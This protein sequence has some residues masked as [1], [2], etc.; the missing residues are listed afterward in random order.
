MKI[1]RQM[2]FEIIFRIVKYLNKIILN[3]Q[4]LISGIE[5]CLNKNLFNRRFQGTKKWSFFGIFRK[6]LFIFETNNF[7]ILTNWRSNLMKIFYGT[8]YRFYSTFLLFF[9]RLEKHLRT[10]KNDLSKIPSTCNIWFIK[11]LN[12][13]FKW[14]L[15]PKKWFLLGKKYIINIINLLYKSN[16]FFILHVI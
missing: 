16:N 1:S 6:V 10:E 8:F 9:L 7:G 2:D 11:L 14:K 4:V 3:F 5:N 12:V 15:Q 13:T